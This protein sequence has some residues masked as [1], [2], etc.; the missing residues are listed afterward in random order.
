MSSL[1]E[2]GPAFAGE[3]IRPRAPAS[4]I[5]ERY[6]APAVREVP[7][8]RRHAAPGLGRGPVRAKG[9]GARRLEGSSSGVFRCCICR[10][11]ARKTDMSIR[12][13]QDLMTP[14]PTWCIPQAPV[15]A[16]A[17]L[18]IDCDCG[19]IPVVDD[20]HTLRPIGVITDRDIACRVVAKG[21]GPAVCMVKDVMTPEPASLRVDA[22]VHECARAMEQL[23]IRRILIV[24]DRGKLIGIVA[25]ADLARAS[26]REPELEHELAELVE[27][28]SEPAHAG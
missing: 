15:E 12:T 28:V 2:D 27:E 5:P 24:D 8:F 7:D 10:A 1:S 20:A 25:Q 23:Q 11:F 13:V 6:A 3:P 18:M 19:A 14:S 4:R 21:L 16:A 26:R 17:R 9:R 22:T